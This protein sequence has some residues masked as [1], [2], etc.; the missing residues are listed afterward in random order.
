MENKAEVF[1]SKQNEL[2][3]FSKKIPSNTELP[4]VPQSGGLFGLFNYDV[5]GN[6]LNA[7]TESIQDKMI[8]QNKVLVNTIKEFSTIYDTFE[9]LDKE[10]IQGILVSVKAAEEA[11]Q[12]ALKGLEGVQKNTDEIT[13]DQAD[14]KQ[15]LDHN[16]QVLTVLKSFKDKIDKIEHITDID[17][18]YTEF[19]S[20][21]EIIEKVSNNISE[22]ITEQNVNITQFKDELSY[23]IDSEITIVQKSISTVQVDIDSVQTDLND[24]KKEFKGQF[25]EINKLYQDQLNTLSTLLEKNESDYQIQIQEIKDEFNKKEA[26]NQVALNTLG[27]DIKVS[28]IVSSVSLVGIVTL[29]ILILS[30]V[31]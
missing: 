25:E 17:Q 10:Y 24:T 19:Y 14:I 31:V 1:N 5:T 9:A 7:L 16:K 11:N 20:M 30:G 15:L 18:L 2:K 29:L 28:K 8:E 21:K 23:K 13:K 22:K 4:S 6:D 26:V 27:K 12:K 3:E